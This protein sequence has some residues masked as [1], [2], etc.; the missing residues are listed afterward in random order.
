MQMDVKTILNNTQCTS[1]SM[2]FITYHSI[3]RIIT[4]KGI[5]N[6]LTLD[7]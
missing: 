4:T 7:K 2:Q 5:V 6:I 3:Y 1:Y